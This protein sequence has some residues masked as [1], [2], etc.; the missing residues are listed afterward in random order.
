MKGLAIR[1]TGELYSWGW[2][3]FAG[4]ENDD[5]RFIPKPVPH[6]TGKFIEDVCGGRRHTIAVTSNP[7]F[8]K[9]TK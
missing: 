1:D 9:R 6:L 3:S 7:T 5:Q 2:S 4:D 8:F